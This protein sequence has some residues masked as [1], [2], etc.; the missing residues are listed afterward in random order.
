MR[1]HPQIGDLVGVRDE[2][3]REYPSRVEGIEGDQLTL[4]RPHNL[5]AEN[6]FDF[7]SPIWV[8]WC[9]PNGIVVRP[10]TLAAKFRQ[11]HLGL[12]IA[13]LTG[14][15]W[16]EQRRAYV[17]VSISAGV[18]MR[19]TAPT[20]GHVDGDSDDAPTLCEID[21]HL[22]DLSEAAMRCSAPAA[23]VLA[24]EALEGTPDVHVEFV[25][26]GTAYA[27]DGRLVSLRPNARLGADMREV[28]VQFTLRPSEADRLRKVVFERQLRTRQVA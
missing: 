19:W 14:P 28:V 17:R 6:R 23:A 25:I 18:H 8:T 27:I 11:D 5:A 4:A 7:G 22:A 21:A 20:V 16:R 13:D 24:I 3:G 1:S 12:W 2:E 9:Q 15:G 26:D 10:A